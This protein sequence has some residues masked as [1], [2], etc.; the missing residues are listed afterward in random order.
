MFIDFYFTDR[1][2][3]QELN[4]DLEEDRVIEIVYAEHLVPEI[5]KEDDVVKNDRVKENVLVK[6]NLLA[7]SLVKSHLVSLKRKKAVWTQ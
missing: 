3:V 1:E 5:E 7:K 2:N 4:L 6:I